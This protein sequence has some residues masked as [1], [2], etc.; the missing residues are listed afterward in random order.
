MLA[1]GLA[2]AAAHSAG[3]N[4]LAPDGTVYFIRTNNTVL[5]DSDLWKTKMPY[6]SAG[7]FT[8][9]KFNSWDTV[10]A[11]NADDL[12]LPNATNST[13]TFT[14]PARF[15][16]PRP[17][18][19][20]ND[21][22]TVYLVT[23]GKAGFTNEAAF[24][25]MGYSYKNVYPGDT[26]FL[27]PDGGISTDQCRHLHGSL[28]NDNGTLYLM[29]YMTKLGVPTMAVLDSWGYWLEDAVPANSFDRLV[30][31]IGILD[32]RTNFE[33]TVFDTDYWEQDMELLRA[34]TDP[35]KLNKCY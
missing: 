9:Y 30:P 28:V 12:A 7:A 29:L 22:G 5:P 26:S 11:A 31:N 8:S 16:Q 18:A 27:I 15:A 21:N 34:N 32:S 14:G 2:Q 23:E 6:T 17:G 24:K 4:V 19:L 1:P 20:I 13:S 10:V 33:L 35:S 25:G 3:T